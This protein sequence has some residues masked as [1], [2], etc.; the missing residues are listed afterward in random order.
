MTG[1]HYLGSSCHRETGQHYLGSSCHRVT[2]QHYLG[3]SCHRVTGQHYLGSSCHR[4]T[5]QNHYS[6]T[7]RETLKLLDLRDLSLFVLA[8]V[9][10]DTARLKQLQKDIKVDMFDTIC[11]HSESTLSV[12]WMPLCVGSSILTTVSIAVDMFS[13]G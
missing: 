5:G 11:V 9:S 7:T 2:G 1:Q 6:H 4:V 3:S 12:H 10:K 13:F 8:L